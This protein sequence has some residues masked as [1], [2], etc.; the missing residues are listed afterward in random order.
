MR[1]TQGSGKRRWEQGDKY[2]YPDSA[3]PAPGIRKLL[4]T[5]SE[6]CENTLDESE[7]ELIPD[8]RFTDGR[9]PGFGEGCWV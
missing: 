2:N 3:A 1:D 9:S 8:A 6:I 4:P 7:G 5:L